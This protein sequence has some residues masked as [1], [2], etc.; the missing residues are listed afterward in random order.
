MRLPTSFLPDE[1]Q[2]FVQLQ[3]T[4]PPG[5]SDARLQ[6][7]LTEVKD[8]F[9]KQPEV[10]SINLITGQNGDQSSARGFVKLKDWSERDGGEQSA[11]AVAR[12]ANRELSPHPRRAHLRGAAARRAR[13]GRQRRLQLPPQGHQRAWPRRAGEGARPGRWICS[14]SARNWS[15]CA[16]TTSTTRRSSRSTSTTH[17]PVRRACRPAPSTARSPAPWAAST[18]TT[19]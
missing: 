11:A 12:R 3:V 2:G 19:S 4:L 9:L 5:A 16:A 15:T 18:S 14:A 6:P 17:A 10:V 7:V 13:A 8:Y 1:D